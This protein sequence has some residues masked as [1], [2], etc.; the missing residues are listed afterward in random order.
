MRL[1]KRKTK[2]IRA[3]LVYRSIKL[4]L[5]RIECDCG[6]IM[7]NTYEWNTLVPKKCE[8]F[9]YFCSNCKNLIHVKGVK[10]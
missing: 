2:R 6:N 1:L 10:L 8:G 9:T 4:E 5:L 3:K 7:K